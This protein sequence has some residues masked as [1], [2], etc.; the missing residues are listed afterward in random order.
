MTA[1]TLKFHGMSL[2]KKILLPF[3]AVLSILGATATLGSLL[4]ITD[5]LEKT[6]ND[7]L[8]A[9]QEVIFREIKEQ[10]IL[11]GTYAKLL[12]YTHSLSL[13]SQDLIAT[14]LL[15]DQLYE[16]LRLADIR[17]AFYPKS[18]LNN[19]PYPSLQSLL[20]QTVRS[21]K[22][23]FRFMAEQGTIPALTVATPMGA[24]GEILVMQTP[25]DKGFLKALTKGLDTTVSLISLQGEVL[26]SSRADALPPEL[27]AKELETVLTDGRYFTQRSAPAP[28][29][30]LYFA[31][32]LGTT[33]MLVVAIEIQVTEMGG[34]VNTLAIRS[35]WTILAALL[36]GSY[37]Y[38]RLIDQIMAPV[39]ELTKATA[40]V[41]E[42]NLSYRIP[43]VGQDELGQTARSFNTMLCQLE[44]L[45]SERIEQETRLATAQE[46]IKYKD[47]LE[48]KNEEIARANHDLKSNLKET[49]ALYQLN[50]AMTSTLDLGILFDRMLNVLKD[51]IHC[52]EMVMLLYNQGNEELDVRK[53]LG[54][55][56]N[57]LSGVT[58]RLDEGITGQAARTQKQQYVPD[59]SQ[60]Q[61]SLDYKGKKSVFG[62]MVSTPMVVK[63]RLCGVLNLHKQK[64]DGFSEKKC[65]VIQAIAN[66]A[67]VAI[68]NAQLYERARNLSNTDELTGLANRRNFHAILQ[69]EQAQARRFSAQFSLIIADIDHFKLYNDTNGHLQGDIV[70]KKV[71][72]LLLQ[73]TRGI[74]L[75]ARFGGEE[76]TILLPKTTGDGAFAA[77]EKLR[78][79]VE[80]AIFPGAEK[81][82]PEGR[83]TMSL[84]IAEFPGD[85][86]DIYELLD[87]ADKALY[88]AKEA[89]RNCT[90]SWRN[91]PAPVETLAP[92]PAETAKS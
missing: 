3:F 35:F 7:R 56:D 71:A 13:G 64:V 20:R 63:N 77:G 9:S 66:Q 11:L 15:S 2:R 10:E 84:G 50:Q 44:E 67:A 73:S 14:S 74:D 86:K 5:T 82:Q 19:L 48:R 42:G 57:L 89:G 58:F 47:I 29:R 43:E 12:E 62:S 76:F 45:Y 28:H 88:I 83:I 80:G 52:D 55:D 53:T 59:V 30:Y 38:Y 21:K 46:E 61:R 91:R 92:S 17:V 16:S 33:D 4:F 79:A 36:I 51:V 85:S 37:I 54:L 25:I 69:R 68:E 90:V 23:R 31:L 24:Q 6:A 26:V 22:P 18:S 41:S 87:L 27:S 75:V 65:R 40:A 60:D 70:L 34:M 78:R 1:P 81:S 39:R 72:S 32:P 49:S 8:V